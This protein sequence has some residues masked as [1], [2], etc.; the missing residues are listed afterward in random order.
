MMG[1]ELQFQ[2]WGVNSSM[3]SAPGDCGYK[4]VSKKSSP[5]LLSSLGNIE[6]VLY[7]RDVV[8]RGK[9][10]CALKTGVDTEVSTANKFTSLLLSTLNNCCSSLSCLPSVLQTGFIH[11]D[12]SPCIRFTFASTRL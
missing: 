6:V 8:Y 1:A 11:A 2:A 5:I 7:N 4:R 12:P 3:K 9:N 10:Q